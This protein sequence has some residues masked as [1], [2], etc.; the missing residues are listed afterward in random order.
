VG[1]TDLMVSSFLK[2]LQYEKRY[3]PHTIQSYHGDLLQFEAFLSE[4]DEKLV[5]QEADY[6]V[7][8]SWIISLMEDS[9]EPRSVN[10]KMASLRA[11]YKFLLKEG[12]IS[13][14]PSRKLKGVKTPRKLPSFV[15]ESELMELLDGASFEES[16]QGYREKVILELLYGTGIRLSELINLKQNQIDSFE[17]VIKVLGKRNKE[18]IIPFNS[19]LGKTIEEYKKHRDKEIGILDSDT[20]LLLTDSGEPT[21][22]MFIYRVVKKN[23]Q[24]TSADKK[25]PHILRHSFATHL[26]NKGADLNAVKD[27][28]G[29][30]SLAA[31]QVYT[32][33]TIEKLKSVHKQAHPQRHNLLNFKLRSMK[34]QMHSLKFDADEKLLDFIQKKLDKLDTFYDRIID[35]EVYLRLNNEGIDNKTVEVK[36]NIPGSQLFTKEDSKSFEEATDM[37]VKSLTR[38]LKKH[39]EKQKAH[40]IA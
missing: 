30:S 22:P 9:L 20:T 7:L 34:I 5:I 40:K 16:F 25:N 12:I 38:R 35:A 29:H 8:R 17:K 2:Y 4:I 23:L 6:Q 3:S 39:K 37:A 13:T 14:D 21:Y 18:R 11:F 19:E 32:H 10:R 24:L 33:N 1:R 36:L 31:T 15:K 27:L 26:L 28:L